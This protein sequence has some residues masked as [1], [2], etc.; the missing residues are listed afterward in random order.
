MRTKA[1]TWFETRVRYQ[2]TMEDG[3][4]KNVTEKYVVDAL[5]VTEAESRINEE[6]SLYGSDFCVLGVTKASY[7]EILFSENDDDDNWYKCKISIITIDE[8]TFREKR[9]NINYL[10]QAKSLEGALKNAKELM[11]D[12]ASDYDIVG[13][14]ETKIV[15]VME[16]EEK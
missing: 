11:K 6:I 1:S 2:K 15:D 14:N 4:E 9:T 10:I 13:L 5:S 7:A 12:T 8:K 3:C 16:N